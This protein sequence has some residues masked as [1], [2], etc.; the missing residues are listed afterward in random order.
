MQTSCALRI[1]RRS[2]SCLPSTLWTQNLRRAV[3]W[4]TAPAPS[5]YAA[6]ALASLTRWH[7]HSLR[8]MRTGTGTRT[9]LVPKWAWGV[10]QEHGSKWYLKLLGHD[11][12]HIVNTMTTAK[13]YW[14][15]SWLVVQ[16]NW[17][18]YIACML[19]HYTTPALYRKGYCTL[20]DGCTKS[21]VW[22]RGAYI[23]WWDVMFDFCYTYSYPYR[24]ILYVTVKPLD[25]WSWNQN[26]QPQRGIS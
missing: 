22:K 16:Q 6:P 14:N 24:I 11:D 1:C 26:P 23:F 12:P 21:L 3:T 19:L 20:K 25:S 7:P 8:S 2:S 17:Q 10:A 4:S 13:H 5:R 18:R 15:V 9:P